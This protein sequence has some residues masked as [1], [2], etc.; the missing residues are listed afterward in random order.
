MSSATS[1]RRNADRGK[2]EHCMDAIPFYY[3]AYGSN[4]PYQRMLQRTSNNISLKGKFAWEN[5]RLTFTKKSDD[6]STKCTVVA[7]DGRIVW[8]A[9]YQVTLADKQK[10]IKCEVGY[11]EV[12]LRIDTYLYPYTWYK[13]Y[14]LA[15]A[16]EHDFPP[17]YI[18]E[19]E[20]APARPDPD[21]AR[22]ASHEPL[23]LQLESALKFR[24]APP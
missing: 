6:E 13:R 21:G 20:A 14:V 18:A 22:S 2:K 10:L 23:L 1:A 5:Q 16:R 19:I 7:S 15:G 8:G 24:T 17:A 3:F 11:H 4:L 12:P 9:I